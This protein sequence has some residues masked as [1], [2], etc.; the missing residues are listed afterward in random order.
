MLRIA[1]GNPNCTSPN[2]VATYSH[3]HPTGPKKWTSPAV[4]PDPKGAPA[5][6]PCPDDAV[7]CDPESWS[8][9]TCGWVKQ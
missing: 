2:V 1:C 9:T 6:Q 8:C 5:P 7:R 3:A 4:G